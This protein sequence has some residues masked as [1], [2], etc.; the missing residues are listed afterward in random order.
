MG[1][2]ADD[3]KEATLSRQVGTK[4]CWQDGGIDALV[5]GLTISLPVLHEAGNT[6][7]IA[8]A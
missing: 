3:K 1:N 4:L 8:G 7:C 5:G 6:G 2:V